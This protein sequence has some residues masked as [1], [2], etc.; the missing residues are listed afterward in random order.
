MS[1]STPPSIA[2]IGASADRSKFGNKA[3]RAYLARGYQVF[4]IHPKAQIIEG[5]QSYRSILE[6]P[7]KSLDRAS[8]YLPPSI[9]LQ[10]IE[11]VAQK[12]VAEVWLNPGAES[13]ALIERG[14][15]LG[16]NII[17]GCS[18]VDIGVNPNDL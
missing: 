5:L 14:R 13:P 3:V 7:A 18:I 8:F 6:V 2:I 10:V 11:E 12:S 16:L 1:S 9:G 15:V 4:P 17:V